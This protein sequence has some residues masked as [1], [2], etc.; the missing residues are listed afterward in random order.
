MRLLRIE[1]NGQP[2]Q[3]AAATVF[4]ELDAPFQ[5]LG[6][7]AHGRQSHS[8]ARAPAGL[9]APES[10]ALILHFQY[11]LILLEAQ[12]NSDV[13]GLRVKRDIIQSLL[14][15][16]VQMYGHLGLHIPT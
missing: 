8:P 3:R 15:N 16:A 14:Q 11:D 10:D 4:E 2:D 13:R 5:Q 1:R 12:A 7:F 6:P 9:E